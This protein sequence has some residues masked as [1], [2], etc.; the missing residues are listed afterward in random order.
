MDRVEDG[1]VSGRAALTLEPVGA[2]LLDLSGLSARESEVLAC[3]VQGLTD[4]E[5]A[6]LLGIGGSTLNS[7][8]VR[9]KQKAG[10]P[11][12]V[13]LVAGAMARDLRARIQELETENERLR[14]LLPS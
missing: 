1:V 12:R 13:R 10:C 7:Y 11:S 14:G 6:K 3:A 2:P 4:L 8:W 9:I 5:T